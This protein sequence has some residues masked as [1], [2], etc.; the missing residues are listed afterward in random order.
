MILQRYVWLKLSQ[1]QN[2]LLMMKE[3]HDMR[4]SEITTDPIKAALDAQSKAM[5]YRDDQLKIQKAQLAATKAQ[6]RAQKALQK[7]SKLR[8]GPR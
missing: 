4:I 7:V 6:Q 8:G 5:S 1:L 3:G 2:V